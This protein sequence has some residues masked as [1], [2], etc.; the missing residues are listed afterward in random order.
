[1]RRRSFC[2]VF[3]SRSSTIRS[4]YFFVFD[5]RFQF[6]NLGRKHGDFGPDQNPELV[7]LA[8]TLLE[9]LGTL[10][11]AEV[12]EGFH[13]SQVG[14]V[15]GQLLRQVVGTHEGGVDVR[16]EVEEAVHQAALPVEL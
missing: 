2:F 5:H 6:R 15:S 4:I 12:L 1:M 14:A 10:G 3:L 11:R 9:S 16:E 8:G 7:D 13:E